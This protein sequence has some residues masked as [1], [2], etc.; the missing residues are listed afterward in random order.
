MNNQLINYKGIELKQELLQYFKHMFLVEEYREEL[1]SLSKSWD[2]L[3]LLSNFGNNSAN[4]NETKNNFSKLTSKL[5]N[6]LSNELLEK[7][8]RQMKFKSQISI[9]ILIRNLYERTADIGFLATDK[10]I[11]EFLEN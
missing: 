2:N 5:L 1:V 4:I 6:H 10:D 8:I 9:D 11:R 3:S 7:T